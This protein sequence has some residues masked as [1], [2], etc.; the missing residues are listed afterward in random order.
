VWPDWVR[1]DNQ[2]EGTSVKELPMEGWDRRRVSGIVK[3]CSEAN[4]ISRDTDA[5][6]A[7]SKIRETM[8]AVWGLPLGI[9]C[10]SIISARDVLLD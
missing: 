10:F 3:P 9:V 6:Q 4:T 8:Q 1:Y 2:R 5:L 7:L